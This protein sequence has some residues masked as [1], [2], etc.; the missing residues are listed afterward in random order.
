VDVVDAG[1]RPVL[2]KDLGLLG[3]ACRCHD[4]T[5]PNWQRP[6]E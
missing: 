3:L 1:I 6:R 4:P 2:A 5:L